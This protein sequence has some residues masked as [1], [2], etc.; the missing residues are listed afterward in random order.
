[1]DKENRP[2]RFARRKERQMKRNKGKKGGTIHILEI[3]HQCL[4]C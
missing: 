2:E 1:L 3:C 4:T